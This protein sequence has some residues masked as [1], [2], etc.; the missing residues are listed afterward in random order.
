MQNGNG[1]PPKIQ[2]ECQADS[3]DDKCDEQAMAVT[4]MLQNLLLYHNSIAQQR[5]SRNWCVG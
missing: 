3:T 5:E 2:L 4:C 1:V